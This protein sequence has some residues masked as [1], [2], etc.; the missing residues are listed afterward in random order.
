MRLHGKH[1]YRFLLAGGTAVILSCAPSGAW[2]QQNNSNQVEIR[3]ATR[4]KLTC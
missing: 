1:L 4:T 2:A 3:H